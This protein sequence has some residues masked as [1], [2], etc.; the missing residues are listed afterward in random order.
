MGDLENRVIIIERISIKIYL[1][2]YRYNH[3]FNSL[4]FIF[5]LSIFFLALG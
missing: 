5:A 2:Q 3:L 1:I 4:N